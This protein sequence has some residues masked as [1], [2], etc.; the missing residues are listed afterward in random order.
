MLASCMNFVGLELPTLEVFIG[1]V[2]SLKKII[3]KK[4]VKKIKIWHL[5]HGIAL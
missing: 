4:F 2:L 1:K 5:L 3:P